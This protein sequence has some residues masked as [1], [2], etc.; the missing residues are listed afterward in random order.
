MPPLKKTL[1][2]APKEIH[3]RQWRQEVRAAGGMMLSRWVPKSQQQPTQELQSSIAAGGLKRRRGAPNDAAPMTRSTRA[4]SGIS[5]DA[6]H[7]VYFASHPNPHPHGTRRSGA[8]GRRAAEA[9]AASA[10]ALAQA[11]APVE[12]APPLAVAEEQESIPVL[13]GQVAREPEERGEE[14]A[15]AQLHEHEHVGG[16]DGD[17]SAGLPL[18]D[19]DLSIGSWPMIQQIDEPPGL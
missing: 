7:D 12:A 15:M 16:G 11:A 1:A 5:A 9:P 3:A 2:L 17:L 8:S 14:E 13:L 6:L 19:L 10:S 18:P 4:R